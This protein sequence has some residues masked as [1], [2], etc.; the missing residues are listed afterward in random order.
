VVK[1]KDTI[2]DLQTLTA[3]LQGQVKDY[4]ANIA[5]MKK[6][7]QDQQKV[8]NDTAVL[9]TEL[10]K[11][12]GT[13]CLEAKDEEANSHIIHYFNT[14]GVLTPSSTETSGEVLPKTN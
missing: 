14:H 3:D 8:E 9:L 1:Q 4:K 2:G 12:L 5:V 10:N 6:V 7:Q 11:L 13:K